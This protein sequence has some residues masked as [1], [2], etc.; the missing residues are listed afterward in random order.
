M[1]DGI[2]MPN[3]ETLGEDTNGV[4][5][6]FLAYRVLTRPEMLAALRVYW[7]NHKGK[8]PKRGSVVTIVSII[9]FDE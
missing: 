3:V 7:Q 1:K 9:G 2:S 5:F 6:R 8:K 4:R